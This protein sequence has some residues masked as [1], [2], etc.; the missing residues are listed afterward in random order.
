MNWWYIRSD[1]S[2]DVKFPVRVVQEAENVIWHDILRA[3]F[4]S[5]PR[6]RKYFESLLAEFGEAMQ[7]VVEYCGVCFFG[8]FGWRR[9][10]KLLKIGKAKWHLFEKMEEVCR[11]LVLLFFLFL[12][13]ILFVKFYFVPQISKVAAL[14]WKILE[15]II[16]PFYP[17]TVKE[18]AYVAGGVLTWPRITLT[19]DGQ[20]TKLVLF[21]FFEDRI[22]TFKL[23]GE[24]R[25]WIKF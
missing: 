16:L 1:G 6:Y 5:L 24:N 4:L 15:G 12:W 8:L 14:S 11:F 20:K 7:D 23:R 25:T 13:N 21:K 9:I 18:I 22:S 2:W 10:S 19:V 3:Y 17:S